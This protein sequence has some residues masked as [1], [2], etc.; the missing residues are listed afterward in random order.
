MLEHSDS[1]SEL[2]QKEVLELDGVSSEGVNSRVLYI[3]AAKV[4]F[5]I[6]EMTFWAFL[7]LSLEAL[8]LYLEMLFR[9]SRSSSIILPSPS[10]F[11]RRMLGLGVLFLSL[12]LSSSLFLLLLFT[13][14][15]SLGLMI[16][17]LFCCLRLTL[18]VIILISETSG[19]A[20]SIFF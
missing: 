16:F 20:K 18:G 13:L 10:P 1:V 5:L 3:L 4:D 17:G 14:S 15:V 7:M 8:L 11:R 9:A 6:S 19:V 2:E 12:S